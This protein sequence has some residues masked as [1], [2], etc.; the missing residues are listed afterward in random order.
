MTDSAIPNSRKVY[1]YRLIDV[2]AER[3]FA[4]KPTAVFA[5]ARGLDARAMQ[6]IAREL[7]FP[8]TT[9]V[10]PARSPDGAAR[11]RVFTPVAELPRAAHPTIAAVFALDCEEKLEPNE[12]GRRVVFEQA[13]GPVSVA[14][15]ARVITVRQQ[16]PEFGSVYPEREAVAALL[17]LTTADLL[18]TPL[19]A[20]SSGTPYL[21]VPVRSAAN[22]RAISFRTSIWD[23]TVR[24]FEA[25]HVA[26][27]CLQ[28]ER[29][30]S[31]AKARVF[32]PAVGVLEDPATEAACGP[33][34][35]YA[36][37]H[38][39]VSLPQSAVV[40]IEQGAEIERPS[41]VQVFANQVDGVLDQVRVGGQC[42]AVGE[43]TMLAP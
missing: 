36:L 40:T 6:V 26:A 37:R 42:Q 7:G 30:G 35:A 11:V 16:V 3:P 24:H 18:P 4:G 41:F 13:D 17:G 33:F 25:P 38:E 29:R 34:V 5:N 1:R 43:G 14:V 19:Q 21:L 23:R 28:G 27:F 32:T 2:F 15:F 39:L 31:I 10:F 20:V 9:F 22:L 12:A 8:Q